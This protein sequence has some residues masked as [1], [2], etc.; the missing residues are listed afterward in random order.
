MSKPENLPGLEQG[1]VSG[2]GWVRVGAGVCPPL[3]SPQQTF[4]ATQKAQ[5]VPVLQL[6]PLPPPTRPRS[7]SSR[8]A[9]DP[10]PKSWGHRQG[11][12]DAQ[13]LSARN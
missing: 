7:P 1:K 6:T 3:Q 4:W 13:A 12:V 10:Q 2:S 9:A 8:R 5:N 11:A